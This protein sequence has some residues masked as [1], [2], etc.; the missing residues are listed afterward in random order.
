MNT[1]KLNDKVMYIA[2]GSKEIACIINM[3]FVF[4]GAIVMVVRFKNGIRTMVTKE[5]I[6][7]LTKAEK[8]LFSS[9]H[10]KICSNSVGEDK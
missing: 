5:C 3:E 4:N 10:Y 1:F 8:I 6:R 2:V 7:H 9:S